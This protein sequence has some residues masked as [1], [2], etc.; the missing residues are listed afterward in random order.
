MLRFTV[1]AL[2]QTPNW[3]KIERDSAQG[4]SLGRFT[5]LMS[6]EGQ[7]RL[8]P[9]ISAHKTRRDQI[10]DAILVAM[11]VGSALGL[12]LDYFRK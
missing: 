10:I 9:T 11:V 6:D 1:P 8:K 3:A 4:S 5:A 7:P 12:V 2:F